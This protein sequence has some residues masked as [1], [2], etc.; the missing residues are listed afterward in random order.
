MPPAAPHDHSTFQPWAALTRAYLSRALLYAIPSVA[1]V[2]GGPWL[3][4]RLLG[5]SDDWS[6][7]DSN[8]LGLYFNFVG[9]A[10]GAA[11]LSG[12]AALPEFL[13][14]VGYRALPLSTRSL[15]TFLFLAPA[16]LILAT[17]LALQIGCRLIFGTDWPVVTTTLSMVA[18][19]M[20]C[21]S[22]GQW[23]KDLYL[24][25]VLVAAVTV[26][27]W[28]FWFVS[29]FY[30]NGFDHPLVP[31]VSLT[32]TDTVI[33]IITA[34][35]AFRLQHIAFRRIRCGEAE[36]HWIFALTESDVPTLQNPPRF[37][38]MT[39][40][41]SPQQ[42][43]NVLGSEVGKH[44][45]LWGGS[46]IAVIGVLT[47]IGTL[48]DDDAGRRG[49][50]TFLLMFGTL[51]VV[52]V[53]LSVTGALIWSGNRMTMRSWV[54]ALPFSDRELSSMLAQSVLRTLARVLLMVLGPMLLTVVV[55]SAVVGDEPFVGELMSRLRLPDR[56][57]MAEPAT[58]IAVTGLVWLT[59][60]VATAIAASGRIWIAVT[61]YVIILAAP[62]SKLLAIRLG[63][64]TAELL[65]QAITTAGALAG[66]A[67]TAAIAV[68]AHRCHVLAPRAFVWCAVLVVAG[69]M[70]AYFLAE[71]PFD[72][73]VGCCAAS[74]LAL[75]IVALPLSV[76][77]NRHR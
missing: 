73:F 24:F 63:A 44:L 69:V 19:T 45:A 46:A 7:S 9:V 29:R 47:T 48:I 32:L 56:S 65:Q 25:R 62:F 34:A 57:P 23:L 50:L 33:L 52:M 14:G 15:A 76:H 22:L 74:L 3:F 64:V 37:S 6:R 70:A 31:W 28:G 20:L 51:C 17:S 10:C 67:I 68:G 4:A 8:P 61:A 11:G 26:V 30:P 71:N 39:E 5:L 27:G 59:S 38:I 12:W 66:V 55:W 16:G 35:G 42:G 40:T 43:L 21:L 36:L 18:F 41:C 1:V 75:P 72:Q 2:I 13:R 60:G 58:F 54:A 53:G 49:A 77:C